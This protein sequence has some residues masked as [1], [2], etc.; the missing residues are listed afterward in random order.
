MVG[1]YLCFCIF[2]VF[3]IVFGFLYCIWWFHRVY[4]GLCALASLG[5]AW[6]RRIALGGYR[7]LSWWVL[8][9]MRGLRISIR[10]LWKS[11]LGVCV[12]CFFL[13]VVIV[14]C[15]PLGP[16]V[17]Y[18]NPWLLSPTAMPIFSILHRLVVPCCV[19]LGGCVWFGI[20]HECKRLF[21]LVW[22]SPG[23][24]WWRGMWFGCF[25]VRGFVF[26]KRRMLRVLFRWMSRRFRQRVS[27]VV[28]WL[29]LSP[30]LGSWRAWL[31]GCFHNR[32]IFS[33][34]R[35][36]HGF[37]LLCLWVVCGVHGLMG[38]LVLL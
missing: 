3:C 29:Q 16:L 36:W 9:R 17:R 7:Y 13:G 5:V 20:L 6:I 11:S 38:M 15:K 33:M 31:S 22:V 37:V 10:P 35:G 30:R 28:F 19:W 23:F 34:S 2:R 4:V 27:L 14:V 12:L 25:I 26:L 18:R 32:Y 1:L 21:V 8:W 24:I